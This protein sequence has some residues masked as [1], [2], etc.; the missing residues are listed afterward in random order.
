MGKGNCHEGSA[1]RRDGGQ[2]GAGPL[3]QAE[4]ERQMWVLK[5]TP[6]SSS[7]RSWLEA[8]VVQKCCVSEDD[9]SENRSEA[10]QRCR[11]SR[12]SLGTTVA[13]RG[14]H[15]N[16]TVTRFMFSWDVC[17]LPHRTNLVC[18]AAPDPGESAQP[19]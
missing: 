17:A 8:R 19:T 7:A 15:S 2:R 18:L 10:H 12:G 3:A 6:G 4:G 14:A 1:W 5:E 13:Q 9:R 11:W 16:A